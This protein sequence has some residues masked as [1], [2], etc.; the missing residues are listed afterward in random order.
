M[1]WICMAHKE[2]DTVCGEPVAMGGV[3]WTD[4]GR[5]VGDEQR[6]TVPLCR[7]HGPGLYQGAISS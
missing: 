6:V 5:N 7:A 4:A 1:T 3:V 2:D